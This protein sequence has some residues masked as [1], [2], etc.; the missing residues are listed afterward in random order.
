[1]NK[2]GWLNWSVI[3][4]VVVVILVLVYVIVIVPQIVPP[5]STHP[6]GTTLSRD[7]TAQRR[8]PARWPESPTVLGGQ[9]GKASGSL[10]LTR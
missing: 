2:P 10:E 8:T 1:M 3:I 5:S 4:A 7:W 6:I 9:L